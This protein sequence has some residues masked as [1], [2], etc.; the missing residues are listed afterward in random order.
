NTPLAGIVFAIEELSRSFEERASGT[1]LT[2]VILAGVIAI[3]LVGEYTYFGQPVVA[4]AARNISLGT[5]VIAILSGLAGGLFSWVT[6]AGVR[7]LPGLPGR[8]QKG[9]PVM[10]AAI[11]GLA[12]VI[13]GWLSH[14]LT[15]GSGYSEARS[16]LEGG[17]H[18][19]WFY[20]PG[21]A[22]ASL[23]AY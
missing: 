9:S 19:P 6:L 22:L 2:A 15:F 12:V 11:C 18:L 10:F 1:A 8:L 13:V 14:G 20:A 21:R 7:G 17:A 16:I 23:L 4:E 3:A 5:I